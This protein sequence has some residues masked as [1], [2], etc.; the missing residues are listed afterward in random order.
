MYINAGFPLIHRAVLRGRVD[1]ACL[2]I[3]HGADVTAQVNNGSTLLHWAVQNG[4]ADL[5]YLLIEHGADTAVQ[6]DRGWTP[7]HVQEGSMDLTFMLVTHGSYIHAR[8]AWHGYESPGQR[9][10]DSITLGDAEEQI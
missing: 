6:D 9:R 3:K 10:V 1:L 5:A 8:H 2:L 4:S 7:L